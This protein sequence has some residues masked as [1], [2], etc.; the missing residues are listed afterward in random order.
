LRAA[1]LNPHNIHESLE[2]RHDTIQ[3]GIIALEGNDDAREA[4]FVGSGEVE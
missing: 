2:I 1:G 3:P 4:R